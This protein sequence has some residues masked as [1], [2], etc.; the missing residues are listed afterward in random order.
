MYPVLLAV[1]SIIR[2]LVLL[3]GF[4][5]AIR[6]ALGWLGKKEWTRQDR[7][8]GV[9]YTS[10]MDTQLLF[11]LLLYVF[12]S[13]IVKAAYADFGAAMGVDEARFFALE[14]VLYMVL[15]LVFAHLGSMLPKKVDEA[16]AKHRRAALWFGL[17]ILSVLVGIP[18][19]RPLFPGL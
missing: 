4:L 9:I 19:Q 8:W 7:L 17:S 15:A 14:H 11:G 1:H 5:A 13:S 18:W 12:F 3:A 10:M 6:A 16:T 2:W